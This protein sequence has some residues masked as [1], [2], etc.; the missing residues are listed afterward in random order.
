MISIGYD[1][2]ISRSGTQL[3]LQLMIKFIIIIKP[4]NACFGGGAQCCPPAAM[5]QCAPT[6]PPCSSSSREWLKMMK[7][8]ALIKLQLEI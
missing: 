4:T 8:N 1:N 3:A 2:G 6:M 7:L 5:M